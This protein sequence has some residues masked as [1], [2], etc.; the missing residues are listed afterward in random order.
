M[1][2]EVTRDVCLLARMMAAN[3]YYSQIEDLM[4]EVSY[5]SSRYSRSRIFKTKTKNRSFTQLSMWRC[6]DELRVRANELLQSSKRDTK[7]YI[8]NSKFHGVLV[9]FGASEFFLKNN[10]FGAE[11]W[12]QVPP[13]EPYRVLLGDLRDKLY[14]TRERSRLLLSHGSSDIPEEA[15]I[16]DIAQVKSQPQKVN[17]RI[18][19]FFSL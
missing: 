17:A 14:N 5:C 6:S 11:F 13:N 1:T 10:N 3:M 8:G 19:I 7:H 2:P 16:T 15:T 4:F 18:S 9:M 12:K